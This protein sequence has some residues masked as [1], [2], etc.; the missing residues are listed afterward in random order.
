MAKVLVVE[1]NELNRELMHEMLH[2]LHHEGDMAKDG[3]EAVE[4]VEQEEYDLIFMDL[5]MPRMGGIEALKAIRKFSK[6]AV[7]FPIIALTASATEEDRLLC[8]KEGMTDFLSKPF[9]LDQLKKVIE[10]HLL[11]GF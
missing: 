10:H 8:Q 2:I 7:P 6:Y 5:H 11:E 1:D 9:E 3:V 4:K